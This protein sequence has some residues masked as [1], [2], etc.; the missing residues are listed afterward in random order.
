MVVLAACVV[1]RGGGTAGGRILVSR[2]YVRMT[3]VRVEGLLVAFSKLLGPHLQLE[4]TLKN[5]G[6]NPHAPE[7]TFCTQTMFGGTGAV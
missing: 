1:S 2:Q 7:I 5:P 6:G 3:R 4:S